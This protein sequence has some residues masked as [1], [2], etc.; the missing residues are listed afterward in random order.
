MQK[1]QS[2]PGDTAVASLGAG[3]RLMLARIDADGRFALWAHAGGGWGVPAAGEGAPG[4]IGFAGPMLTFQP[5]I[6][7]FS[8]GLEADALAYRKGFGAAVMPSL[9]CSF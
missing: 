4:P 2:T 6:Q 5:F 1:A 7:R 9:R 8:I 3:G